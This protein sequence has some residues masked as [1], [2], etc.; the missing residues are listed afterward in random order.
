MSDTLDN[1]ELHD[2]SER[3]FIDLEEGSRN[4]EME[5]IAEEESRD[6]NHRILNSIADVFQQAQRTYAGHRKHIAVLKKIQSKAYQQG[7]SEAFNYW[8]NKLVTKIFPNEEEKC[9]W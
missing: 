5:T 6:L 4:V 7:Y 3:E 8:F 2:G 9:R 1:I